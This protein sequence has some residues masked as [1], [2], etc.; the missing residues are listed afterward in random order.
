MGFLG[1]VTIKNYKGNMVE[2]LSNFQKKYPDKRVV[3]A[4]QDKETLE[5]TTEAMTTPS[6][7]EVWSDD[8]SIDGIIALL[9]DFK[10]KLKRIDPDLESTEISVMRSE[11]PDQ[12]ILVA[13]DLD[14]KIVYSEVMLPEEKS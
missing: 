14:D 1:Q 3:E 8:V 2:S 4:V 10:K 13:R 9:K 7:R 6:G 5:I 11:Y 12:F